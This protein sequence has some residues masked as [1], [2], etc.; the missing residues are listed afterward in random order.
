MT[1][2]VAILNREAVAIAADSA[3][4]ITRPGGRKIYNTANKLFA[5]STVEPVAVM[6]YNKPSLVDIP[7]ETV[8]KECRREFA[9]PCATV[10]EYASQ[11]IEYLSSL[12]KYMPIKEQH[13]QIA[14]IAGLELATVRVKVESA[15]K[16]ASSGETLKSYEIRDM[17]LEGIETRIS[18]LKVDRQIDNL[19]SPIA[20]RQINDAI[21]NWTTFI[22]EFWKDI[23]IDREIIQRARDMVRTALKTVSPWHSGVVIT[24]FGSEQWFPALSHFLVD[25][26]IGDKVRI[27]NRGY[28]DI[29]KDKR[30]QIRQFAQGDMVATFMHGIHP[31]HGKVVNGYADQMIGQMIGLLAEQLKGRSNHISTE[32]TELLM[33]LERVRPQMAKELVDKFDNYTQTQHYDPI[34]S[35]VDL[36]PKE[37]LAEMAEALVSLTSLKRRVSPTDETVGGPIDVAIISKGD[38]FVWIK[39][40]HYFKPELNP[41]YSY[42]DQ[43]LS[44]R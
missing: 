11:F 35:I 4:T 14:R 6:I 28:T 26:I 18:Q 40:K 10:E 39:R 9:L 7:W 36:L 13:A 12:A 19:T 29:G 31:N 38:G 33:E 30:S 8:I 24:G 21:D 3:V 17:L 44:R 1:A 34:R 32:D 27:H 16:A 23:S 25:G 15:I 42:R 22:G 37:E 2:E 41:R 20:G 43:R 5:L